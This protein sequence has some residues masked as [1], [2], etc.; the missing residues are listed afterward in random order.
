MR[1]GENQKSGQKGQPPGQQ[2]KQYA[3]TWT[4]EQDKGWDFT[5]KS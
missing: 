3:I 1:P 2:D 5:D 4:Q